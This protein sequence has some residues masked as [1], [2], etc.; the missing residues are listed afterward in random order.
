[1]NPSWR[2]YAP[3]SISSLAEIGANSVQFTPQWFLT[4]GV[5][6]L[7]PQLGLT[8]FNYELKG[9]ISSAKSFGLSVSLFPQLGPTESL[10]AYWSPQNH[11]PEWWQ[12][13]FNSYS[14]FILN[15]ARVAADDDMAQLVLGGKAVLPAFSGGTFL[16]GTPTNVPDSIDTQWE[17][18]IQQIRTIYS[19]RLIWA[20]NVQVAADPLPSFI[21]LFD[22]IYVTVDA[23][24]HWMGKL[25]PRPSQLNSGMLSTS[26]SIPFILKQA[27]PSS[28][29]WGIPQRL[30]P[31][32]AVW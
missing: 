20:N 23:P 11:G 3:I 7:Q 10:T 24:S 26:K 16:D 22:S 4:D 25:A 30:K 12:N 5:I 17:A 15:Y 29:L 8:P 9:L 1:M 32:K 27:S 19:G 18:L 31:Y 21:N 6:A 13:W 2:T 28:W 14:T